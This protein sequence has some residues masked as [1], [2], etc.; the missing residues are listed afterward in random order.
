ML[1]L[2]TRKCTDNIH[3][4]LKTHLA[5]EICVLGHILSQARLEGCEASRGLNWMRGV[6]MNERGEGTCICI[7]FPFCT[8]TWMAPC[9]VLVFM[10]ICSWCLLVS[11]LRRGG[12]LHVLIADK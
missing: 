9:V 8:T 6:K 2:E 12:L 11:F 5:S 10:S 1:P 7:Y 3:Q 4:R